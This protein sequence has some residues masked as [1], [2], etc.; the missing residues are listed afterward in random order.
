MPPKTAGG[1]DV[2]KKPAAA[3]PSTALPLAR[4]RPAV[5]HPVASPR[6]V[7]AL[8]PE[9]S[10]SQSSFR[11]IYS[12][13]L[14]PVFAP[15]SVTVKTLCNGT[16]VIS[17]LIDSTTVADVAAELHARLVLPPFRK[18][19]LTHWG[20]ALEPARRLMQS[21][22]HTASQLEASIKYADPD[23]AGILTRVR[24]SSPHL[25]TRH[26]EV[27]PAMLVSELKAE[28]TAFL[29]RGVHIWYGPD[30]TP[31]RAEGATLLCCVTRP[32]DTK[33]LTSSMARGEQFVQVGLGG[34]KKDK[35]KVRRTATGHLAQVGFDDAVK[36][37][38]P[39]K[40]QAL[41]Y[42]GVPL[43]DHM[44]LSAYSILQNDAVLLNFESPVNKPV[45]SVVS[46]LTTL[47]GSRGS[48]N[49]AVTHPC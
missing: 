48:S 10:S 40:E 18:V 38:L 14:L 45:V 30:G 11:M 28:I 22:L 29:K 1:A 13:S 19:L 36:L 17:D 23:R 27:Y 3:R 43:A 37:L 31:I 41:S 42:N 24:L 9:G 8:H 26:V 16:H 39:A 46:A 49:R 4:L 12:S 5:L 25:I 7:A 20:R 35:W 6:L 44:P 34:D 21:G 15:R 33:N 47:T 2:K 32:L